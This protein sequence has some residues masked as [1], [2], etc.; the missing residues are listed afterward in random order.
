MTDGLGGAV[1]IRMGSRPVLAA[2]LE[3]VG[4]W[5]FSS[6][7]AVAVTADAEKPV[8]D[9]LL[10]QAPPRHAAEAIWIT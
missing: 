1:E 5:E 8:L 7:E 10:V 9:Q 3:E 2:E 4:F 6:G